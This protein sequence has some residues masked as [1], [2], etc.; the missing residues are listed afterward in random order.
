MNGKAALKRLEER[1]RL[2]QRRAQDDARRVRVIE[3]WCDGELREVWTLG[4]PTSPPTHYKVNDSGA[5]G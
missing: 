2:A 4:T 5:Q 1:A 3:V